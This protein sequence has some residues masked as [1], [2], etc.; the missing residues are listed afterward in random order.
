[1]QS[2]AAVNT[3]VSLRKR[4]AAYKCFSCSGYKTLRS[5]YYSHDRIVALI[6]GS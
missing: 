1:M 3:P 4:G 6:K 2:H 5:Y